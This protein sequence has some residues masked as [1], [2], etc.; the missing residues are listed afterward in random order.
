MEPE[1]FLVGNNFKT[2]E[3]TIDIVNPYS[4]KVVK[5]IY[6]SQDR[7]TMDAF[8]YLTESFKEYS[9]LPAYIRSRLLYEISKRVFRKREE[10]ADLITL[11]TGKP[12]KYS[13]IEIERAVLTFRLGVNASGNIPGEII[14]LDQLPGSEG[15]TGYIKRFPLGI[16]FAITPW[17]FPINL[18]AHKISPALAS[19]NVVLLKPATASMAC[20]LEVGK[21]VYDAARF[22]GIKNPPINVITSAGS[23]TEKFISDGRVK[24]VSFT[25]SHDVGWNL[26]RIAHKQKVS[27]ELG[28]NATAVIEDSNDIDLTAQKIALGGFAQAG[29]SC[30]SVQRVLVNEN[31]YETFREMLI[32]K[33]KNLKY[34][35]PFDPETIVGPMI[36]SSEAERVETWVN[37][38]EKNNAKIICGGQRTGAVY[39]PT[40]IENVN[41]RDK[42]NCN[43]VFAPV[44]TLTPFTYFEGA[45]E[46]VNDSDFGLQAGIFTS[47]I[48][49]ALLAFEKIDCGGVIV[50]DVP[51]YRM[52]SMPYGGVKDSGNSREGI[53][54][55]IKEMTEL[56]IMVITNKM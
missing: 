54:Y 5:R 19:G 8:E 21:I 23:S 26:K 32:E 15:K 55:A 42:V 11:E 18:V 1:K 10:L 45:I 13:K 35:D 36:N 22:V 30:I 37:E 24:M 51:T 34:G 39:L 7:D 43:E 3:E 40:L 44:I 50:N 38:A 47:N 2:S 25:G 20:G 48:N 27:L 41:D 53:N 6:R 29:Q 12:I 14:N 33:T 31:I 46:K 49:N 28:G 9:S 52:D 4:G 16:I 17:N 56:K